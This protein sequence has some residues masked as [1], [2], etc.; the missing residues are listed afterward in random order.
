MVTATADIRR[1]MVTNIIR[2]HGSLEAFDLTDVF[3]LLG[4]NAKTGELKITGPTREE[5]ASVFFKKGRIVHAEFGESEG[6]WA[7]D[8]IILWEK[9]DF[10]F[11]PFNETERLSI[12]DVANAVLLDVLTRRDT[13]KLLH[14]DLPPESMK[15]SLVT[16]IDNPPQLS[17]DEWRIL[18]LV[19]DKRTL[20]RIC[21]K[22]GD[23]LETK[24]VLVKL[25]KKAVI[26]A[27][28]D[29]ASWY[30]ISPRVKP[31]KEVK[32]ERYTPSRLR[33]NLLLKGLDGKTSLK[34]I[35]DKL[36]MDEHELFEDLKLLYD[37][38]W[39]NLAP[40]DEKTFKNAVKDI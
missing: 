36:N 2:L 8:H 29:D 6:F 10:E 32:G 18:S 20:K 34:Q 3:Q 21:E 15:L 7:L 16:N 23:E 26:K 19:N 5:T 9:G 38:Q 27:N 31:T 25:F 30:D 1:D 12:N 33:T 39:L 14:R 17:S 40:E 13:L 11:I 35:K 28:Q 22:S 24:K 4:M 37:T